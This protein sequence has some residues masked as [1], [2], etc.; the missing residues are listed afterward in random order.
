MRVRA[1]ADGRECVQRSVSSRRAWSGRERRAVSA[2][3]PKIPFET[4]PSHRDELPLSTSQALF[5][6]TSR[7]SIP[8]RITP[9]CGN[10][11]KSCASSESESN[12]SSKKKRMKITLKTFEDIVAKKNLLLIYD[13]LSPFVT[14]LRIEISK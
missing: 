9:G 1:Y 14:L 7:F 13:A 3:H 6:L 10:V 11:E 4:N 8:F 2:P 5:P 12:K